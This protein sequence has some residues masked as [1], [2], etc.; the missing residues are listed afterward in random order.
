MHVAEQVLQAYLSAATDADADRE[1]ER[2]LQDVA[3]PIVRGIAASVCRG[4]PAMRADAEDLVSDTL[5]DLLRR[6]RAVR[7]DP[8]HPIHDMRGYIATC[9]YNRWHELLSERHPARNRLRNQVQYLCSHDARLAL[10]RTAQGILVCG[11]EEWSGREPA[12]AASVEGLSLPARSDPAAENRAQTAAL[13]LAV[14]RSVGAPLELETLAGALARLIDAEQQRVD[15]PL[16][17]LSFTAPAADDALELRTSL[18]QLWDD[19]LKLVP[20]QRV[21]LLLNL[22][23]VHGRECLSL[24]PITRTATIREIAEAVGM[25]PERFAALWNDLPLPDAAIAELL[26]ASPRQVIKLRRLARERL[27]RFEKS[28]R[29][30]NIRAQS[31]SSS[32]RK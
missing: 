25:P 1:V 3:R 8:S 32:E 4:S 22:R 26:D 5:T 31:R 29:R 27:Q 2:L 17:S 13:L 12:V 6:L 16:T 20:A 21:A 30:Q 19:V 14:F 7:A 10:W 9:A 18:R 24:L 28:R 23:D 11:L 15:V